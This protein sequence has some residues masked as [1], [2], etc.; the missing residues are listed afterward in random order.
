MT[1]ILVT[2]G[3]GYI[4]SH[5]AKLL[6]QSGYQ[7]ICFDNLSTGRAEAVRYGPLI[8]ADLADE[9]AIRRTL[10]DYDVQS[11]VH[12]AA[13]AYVGESIQ[14]PRKY[15]ANNV[16]NGL[17]LL[18]AM[19]DEGVRSLVF[20]SSCAIYGIP[21]TV[22]ITES[23][24]QKPIN[25]YGESKVIFERSLH[26]YAEAYGLRWC[27]LRYFNAAGADPDGELG[28]VHDP[29]THLIPLVMQA[30]LGSGPCVSV[31]GTDYDTPD[32]TA[33]RDYVHVTD[34][35]RA[36]VAAIDYL[37]QGGASTAVNLGTGEGYSVREIIRGIQRVAKVTPPVQDCPRRPGDP[38]VLVA[39]ASKARSLLAWEPRYSGLDQILETAWKWESR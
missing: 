24:P 25:P 10:R 23:A 32:G 34:L 9:R 12:F 18:N 28:E 13:S 5:T 15:L 19:I 2:G 21:G 8:E 20:S 37:K 16:V 33:I 38:A 27:A 29:E 4:G 26:W 31:F 22:P 39:D 14:D 1:S 30:A 6:A 3:A 17:N 36:H 7:P 35:A 11:V